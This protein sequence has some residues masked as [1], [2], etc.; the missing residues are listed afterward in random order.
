MKKHIFRWVILLA[1]GFGVGSA[2]GYFQ[3]KDE[4]D[5]ETITASTG[6]KAATIIKQPKKASSLMS[7]EGK[8]SLTD[9][10]GQAVTQDT[11]AGNYKLIFFG[12]TYC[13]AICP[14]ELQ[15]ITLIMGEL[16]DLSEKVTPLFITIDPERDNV[17]AMNSYVTQFHE[18]LVGL[19]GSIKQI[20][21][22][23]KSFKVYASK[24]ENEMMDEYMMDHSSFMY[25]MSPENKLIALYPS[26]DGAIKI[27]EE[28]K[29]L[30]TE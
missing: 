17:A 12:F 21:D 27:A 13:P 5:S 18:K 4:V 28:V 6:N 29:K 8:F 19:T 23:K 20:E 9:H 1:I 2:I 14:A 7:I 15:K 16:E 24:V 26:K 11:Y 3:S 30:I 25:L 22:V 10:E